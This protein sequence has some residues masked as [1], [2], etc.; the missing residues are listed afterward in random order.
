MK[1]IYLSIIF[2][3]SVHISTAQSMKDSFHLKKMPF[4]YTEIGGGKKYFNFGIT[5]SLKNSWG[6]SFNQRVYEYVPENYPSNYKSGFCLF[7]NC[8][9]KDVKNISTIQIQKM[10]FTKI[11]GVRYS[12]AGGF[13]EITHTKLSFTPVPRSSGWFDFSSN[14]YISEQRK[15]AIGFIASSSVEFPVG[16]VVGFKATT[17]AFITNVK[18]YSKAGVEISFLYGRIREKLKKKNK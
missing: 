18:S 5:V 3:I 7:G 10:F 9:P 12:L 14:Y 11:P 13:G 17:F 15:F 1:T 16:R 2:F 8:E 4:I 6:L